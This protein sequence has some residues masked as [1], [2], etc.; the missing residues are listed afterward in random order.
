MDYN[1]YKKLDKPLFL[2]GAAAD[3]LPFHLPIEECWKRISNKRWW[4]GRNEDYKRFFVQKEKFSIVDLDCRWLQSHAKS[5]ILLEQ[6]NGF[7]SFVITNGPCTTRAHVEEQNLANC[8]VERDGVKIFRLWKNSPYEK[9]GIT[10]SS[11]LPDFEF[12]LEPGD[13]LWIPSG[14]WHEVETATERAIIEGFVFKDD[15]VLANLMRQPREIY[16]FMQKGGV[17]NKDFE[18]VAEQCGV[19]PSVR[20][21][22]RSLSGYYNHGVAAIA[23]NLSRKYAIL[24]N[25]TTRRDASG[26]KRRKRF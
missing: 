23:D 25:G 1:D 16:K 3:A 19:K 12:T 21:K 7:R 2:K 18:V 15:N 22:K 14:Y 8:C 17:Y 9:D 13:V 4:R 24:Q 5:P 26:Q 20:A 6:L 10:Y 11:R